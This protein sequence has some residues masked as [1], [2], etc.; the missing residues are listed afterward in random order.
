MRPPSVVFRT[1]V[2]RFLLPIAYPVEAFAK[3]NPEV[4][5]RLSRVPKGS[6][7]RTDF[8]GYVRSDALIV[9]CGTV[10]DAL[11]GSRTT[12]PVVVNETA[13]STIAVVIYEIFT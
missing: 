7:G 8:G 1:Y 11:D 12:A 9:F 5:L 2:N 6:S 3:E 4:R 13:P 10:T